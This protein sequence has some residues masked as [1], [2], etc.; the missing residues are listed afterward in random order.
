MENLEWYLKK[1]SDFPMLSEE[2]I[3]KYTE[4]LKIGTEIQKAEAQK[5]LVEG[6]LRLVVHFAKKYAN[7]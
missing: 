4:L 3:R 6:N 2:E 7:I 5:K 1:I